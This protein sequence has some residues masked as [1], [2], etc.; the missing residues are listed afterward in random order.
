MTTKIQI[1]VDGKPALEFDIGAH[2]A[3]SAPTE[4][5]PM[6]STEALLEELSRRGAFAP[7]PGAPLTLT[8]DT[9]TLGSDWHVLVRGS[10]LEA[11]AE[12]L[13]QLRHPRDTFGSIEVQANPDD[14]GFRARVI[15]PSDALVAQQ[16]AAGGPEF[17]AGPW[18]PWPDSETRTT[19]SIDYV[20]ASENLRREHRIELRA[21]PV[22]GEAM[23][24]RVL[25]PRT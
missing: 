18:K 8:N 17:I 12:A 2:I 21:N 15:H 13:W 23:Q 20:A 6:V 16:Q 19:P 9:P 10:Q 1:H 11:A 25:T 3:R 22:V 5:L 4:L 7:A 24:Y 14:F